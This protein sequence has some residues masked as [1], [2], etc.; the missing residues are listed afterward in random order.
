MLKKTPEFILNIR[1]NKIINEESINL[2]ISYSG[3]NK[4]KYPVDVWHIAR[5]LGFD[6]LEANFNDASLSGVMFDKTSTPEFLKGSKYETNRAIILN[7]LIARTDQA[8]TIAHFIGRF[9]Y[10]VEENK[11][12]YEV[13]QIKNLSNS[14]SNN[15]IMESYLEMFSLKLLMP[16]TLFRKLVSKSAVSHDKDKLADEISLAFMVNKESVLKRLYELDILSNSKQKS[17]KFDKCF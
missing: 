7:K 5:Y 2:I 3:L 1:K 15:K 17:I 16:E 8:L 14:K 4:L 6:V 13:Y 11:D 10:D 12:F 9:I